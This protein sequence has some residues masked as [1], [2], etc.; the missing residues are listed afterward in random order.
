M[1]HD[2]QNWLLEGKVT[3]LGLAHGFGSNSRPRIKFVYLQFNIL[4]APRLLLDLPLLRV[5]KTEDIEN[6]VFVFESYLQGS[7]WDTR[8]VLHSNADSAEN[9]ESDRA[10]VHGVRQKLMDSPSSARAEP[11]R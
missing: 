5:L 10:V 2:F 11:L 8:L 9:A 6:T 4:S 3:Q 7:W 1:E